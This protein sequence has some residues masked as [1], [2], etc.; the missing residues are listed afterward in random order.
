MRKLRVVKPVDVPRLRP[1]VKLQ[2]DRIFFNKPAALSRC[3]TVY[4]MN[5]K[6]NTITRQ[7]LHLETIALQAGVALV[8][9]YELQPHCL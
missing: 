6:H 7:N 8:M 1:H 5:Q 2:S 9:N 3:S 4:G